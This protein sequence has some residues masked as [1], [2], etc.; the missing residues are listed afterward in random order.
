MT[1]SRTAKDVLESDEIIVPN[2][3]EE[4]NESSVRKTEEVES[5]GEQHDNDISRELFEARR[6]RW[7]GASTGDE[8]GI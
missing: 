1:T 8:D 7:G 4:K 5:E 3:G 2:S 6:R